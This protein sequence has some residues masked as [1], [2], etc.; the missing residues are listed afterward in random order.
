MSTSPHSTTSLRRRVRTEDVIL[1]MSLARAAD[2][3]TLQTQIRGTRRRRRCCRCCLGT[4]TTHEVRAV[5]HVVFLPERLDEAGVAVGG[6]LAGDGE[7]AFDVCCR[8]GVSAP[9][10]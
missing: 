5:A 9:I 3:R 1:P 7:E 2:G 6:L 8:G 4:Y 10:N